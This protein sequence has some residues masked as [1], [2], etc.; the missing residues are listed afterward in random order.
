MDDG[1]PVGMVVDV[2]GFVGWDESVLVGMMLACGDGFSANFVSGSLF[3]DAQDTNI[4]IDAVIHKKI[5]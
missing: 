4:V 1:V 3:G 5:G 2:G